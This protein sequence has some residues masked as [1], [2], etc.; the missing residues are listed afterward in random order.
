[1]DG[2]TNP[3][4]VQL[5][6]HEL[7]SVGAKRWPAIPRAVQAS[8]FPE[9]NSASQHPASENW[10][11]DGGDEPATSYQ[12]VVVRVS[13]ERETLVV[14][15]SHVARVESALVRNGCN[16]VAIRGGSTAELGQ[17]LNRS[18]NLGQPKN[19]I[20]VAGGNDVAELNR[21]EGR[22]LYNARRVAESLEGLVKVCES[23]FPGGLYVTGT[24]IPRMM[25]KGGGFRDR[26]LFIDQIEDIDRVIQQVN[27]SH[28]HY[29]T[30]ALVS[31]RC[32]EK[33]SVGQGGDH[34]VGVRLGLPKVDLYLKDKVHLNSNGNVLFGRMVG[35]I[36]DSL[37]F[38]NYESRCQLGDSLAD[39]SFLWK[40]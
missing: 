37:T 17:F 14:G 34:K 29:L 9:A 8:S 10:R 32:T 22:E 12:R 5:N 15:T 20:I 28:H 4:V 38:D 23:K 21:V 33:R 18:T 31:D 2:R 24:I 40:F 36:L 7:Q 1:M 27:G 19:V 26:C 11:W 39:G 30:D 16:V 6:H 35:L 25:G 13:D 3:Q